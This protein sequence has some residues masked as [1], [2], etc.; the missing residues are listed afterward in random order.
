MSAHCPIVI[1]HDKVL[2]TREVIVIED[3]DREVIVVEDDD[4]TAWDEDDSSYATPP[5]MAQPWVA[6]ITAAKEA[7]SHTKYYLVCSI[8]KDRTET[9]PFEPV[10]TCLVVHQELPSDY[11]V[12]TDNEVDDTYFVIYFSTDGHQMV[13]VPSYKTNNKVV[14]I[15]NTNG[16]ALVDFMRDNINTYCIEYHDYIREESDEESDE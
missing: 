4:D 6:V 10:N 7:C 9:L 13:F 11:K 8:E 2:P 1:D 16:A 3:V 5:G 14:E 12:D 15:L